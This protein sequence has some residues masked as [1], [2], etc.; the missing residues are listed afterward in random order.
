MVT[1]ASRTT[2]E[3]SS[4]VPGTVLL[5]LRLCRI[6]ITRIHPK[7]S[8]TDMNVTAKMSMTR[9]IGLVASSHECS[10]AYG[11]CMPSSTKTTP[12]MTNVS[13]SQTLDE[14]SLTRA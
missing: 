8:A 10:I 2:W 3:F 14:T 12:L 6:S 1:A 13:T 5:S 9:L 4:S 11:S 7:R